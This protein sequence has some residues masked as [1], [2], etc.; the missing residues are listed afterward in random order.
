MSGPSVMPAPPTASSLYRRG[1]G[2]GED[3]ARA[4]SRDILSCESN[5][6]A[7]G[8]FAVETRASPLPPT[9][10]YSACP[11]YVGLVNSRHQVTHHTRDGGII[12][13]IT[14]NT[15]IS[16]ALLC[17][18]LGSSLALDCWSTRTTASQEVEFK[19][20]RDTNVINMERCNSTH[21]TSCFKRWYK[22]VGWGDYYYALGCS[23]QAAAGEVE[24]MK[25]NNHY[26]NLV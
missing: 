6:G 9:C 5:V 17:S 23:D 24:K 3:E 10:P 4:V 19:A 2:G 14:M 7:A 16:L 1:P 13:I 20:M 21:E 11:R 25:V 18:L 26:M 22:V 12:N 8:V 15:I